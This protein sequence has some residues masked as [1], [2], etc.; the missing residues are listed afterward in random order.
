MI[1]AM[2]SHR[3]RLEAFARSLSDEE[4]ERPVPDSDWRVKDFLIHL[5]SFDPEMVRWLERVRAG[6]T[7]VPKTTSD[8][9]PYNI[10]TW[11]NAQ[12][13][14]RRDWP[15][16][17]ILEEG[18]EGRKQFEAT[19]R[20]MEDEHIEQVVDFPGDNKRDPAK[21]QL[22][23]FLGGLGRHDPV[24]VA[25]IMKALPERSEDPELRAWLDDGIVRWYQNA[26]S[27]P[28]RR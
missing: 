20:T 2:K 18:V 22:K 25:D 15:L 4:L 16:E 3:Q 23:L 28:P 27:G 7:S 5:L 17:R 12:V 19:L 10:D 1:D 14:E 24:H 11:N 6:D 21:V 26:M 9:E 13:A 8:G